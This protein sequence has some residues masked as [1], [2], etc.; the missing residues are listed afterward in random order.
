MQSMAFAAPL[1]AGKAA[2]A[3]DACASSVASGDARADREASRERT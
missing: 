1:L 2:N 3:R